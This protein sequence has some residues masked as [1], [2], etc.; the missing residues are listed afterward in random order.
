LSRKPSYPLGSPKMGRTASMAALKAFAGSNLTVTIGT[1]PYA[2]T[3]PRCASA[4]RRSCDRF[5]SI[6]C[7]MW[8]S[9]GAG[10]PSAVAMTPINGDDALRLGST[11]VVETPRSPSNPRSWLAW[12]NP[13]AMT[14][15]SHSAIRWWYVLSPELC[16]RRY[17]QL[18]PTT[19]GV[20][21]LHP[22]GRNAKRASTTEL[23]ER[24][25]ITAASNCVA[26][27]AGDPDA[28]ARAVER[29][30]GGLGAL[31]EDGRLLQSRRRLPTPS[32][33]QLPRS[34]WRAPFARL[35]WGCER[36]TDAEW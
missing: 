16:I 10:P 34:L 30:Q 31:A 24:P 18:W 23:A 2:C 33:G 6:R 7:L 26:L 27:V 9:V 20:V 32:R 3:K 8:A 25:A 5:A 21:A 17:S 36:M 1:A 4:N 14:S 29:R 13:P 11:T 28:L 22:F 35:A 15:A 12:R 19:P